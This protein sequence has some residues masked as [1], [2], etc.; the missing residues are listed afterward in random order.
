M[1]ERDE[2]DKAYNEGFTFLGMH[3]WQ[4]LFVLVFVVVI[5]IGI[6]VLLFPAHV[7]NQAL[8]TAEGVVTKTLNPE[9]AIENYEWFKQQFEDYKAIQNKI[10]TAQQSVDR[11]SKS[12]GERSKW[13]FDDKQEYSRLAAILDGL[14][15]Q[16][17]DM[18]SQY[19]AKSKM[20][21][22]SLFKDSAVPYQLD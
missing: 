10:D 15:Y 20:L 8:N 16:A 2:F 9:N 3:G 12:A 11:F 17:Q 22:R 21:N 6:R 13:T 5:S 1:R 18:K 4:L 14:K 7:A 19:N